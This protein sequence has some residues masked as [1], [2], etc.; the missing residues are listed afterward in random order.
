MIEKFSDEEL[1]QI[2]K[3]L[4]VPTST[5]KRT[6]CAKEIFELSKLW[7][8]KQFHYISSRKDFI[9]QIIDMT[10]CNF[11]NGNPRT[12]NGVVSNEIEDE[13]RQMFQEILE[14][15]KKHN[16]KWEGDAD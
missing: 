15:I 14:I 10:L 3:E 5:A 1:R 11:K 2:K 9:Y 6:V 13:Y 8:D 16:R 4:G 12:V 7:E